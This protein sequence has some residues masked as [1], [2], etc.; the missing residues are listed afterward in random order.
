M[1]TSRICKYFFPSKYVQFWGP[2]PWYCF[3]WFVYS[4]RY[5]SFGIIIKSPVKADRIKFFSAKLRRNIS[6]SRHFFTAK[7]IFPKSRN[8]YGI[9]PKPRYYLICDICTST[10]TINKPRPNS[11]LCYNLQNTV[12]MIMFTM[13]LRYR[14]KKKI[15]SIF[16]PFIILLITAVN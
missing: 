6:I 5:E 4:I 8:L 9:I 2:R 13:D 10:T 3:H 12:S 16:L 1:L 14:S 15:A 7:Y 11:A